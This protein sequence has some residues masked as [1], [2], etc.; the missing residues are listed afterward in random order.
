MNTIGKSADGK[1]WQVFD[2]NGFGF[3][4]FDTEDQA[5]YWCDN[6]GIEYTV[7]E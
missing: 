2:E 7:N 4:S 1:F 6:N 5:K 3:T